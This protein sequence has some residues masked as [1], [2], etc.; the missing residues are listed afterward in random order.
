M[1]VIIEIFNLGNYIFGFDVVYVVVEDV[2]GCFLVLFEIILNVISIDFNDVFFFFDLIFGCGN[3]VVFMILNIFVFFVGDY[4][5]NVSFG[6]VSV[7]LVSMGDFIGVD[8]EMLFMIGVNEDYIFVF[9]SVMGFGLDFCEI[10]FLLVI[11]YIIFIFNVFDVFFVSIIVCF[12]G[13]GEGIFDLIILENI[14]NGNI[15]LFVDFY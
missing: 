1:V 6:L 8:G 5:F 11:E 12:N 15:G 13:L 14:I 4:I 3:I 2:V 10:I 7:G 9:N